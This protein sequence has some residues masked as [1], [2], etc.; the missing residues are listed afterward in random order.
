MTGRGTGSGLALDRVAQTVLAPPL[1]AARTG[2]AERPRKPAVLACPT[3]NAAERGKRF[4]R[5]R[6]RVRGTDH[7]ST[8][9]SA[10]A[11]RTETWPPPDAPTSVRKAGGSKGGRSTPLPD[12]DV[13]RRVGWLSLR[14]VHQ[15]AP[16]DA[17]EAA[18]GAPLEATAED[19]Q[20]SPAR[21]AAQS[22]ISR[23]RRSNRS[24]RR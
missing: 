12:R 1:E 9:T 22:S 6:R 19:Y 16:A 14:K 4:P 24:V 8:P 18:P 7:A 10:A 13:K 5:R 17:L 15:A 11:A 20:R 3:A 23:R 21:Y 2:S